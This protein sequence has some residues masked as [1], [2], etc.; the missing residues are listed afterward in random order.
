MSA[1]KSTDI[2]FISEFRNVNVSGG[3]R[4]AIL[5]PIIFTK[6]SLWRL[7]MSINKNNFV[8]LSL[9]YLGSA[10]IS[11]TVH[12]NF[13]TGQDS[14]FSEKQAKKIDSS[15]HDPAMLFFREF[16]ASPAETSVPVSV[17]DV[18]SNTSTESRMIRV[19]VCINISGMY[20]KDIEPIVVQSFSCNKSIEKETV[21]PHSVA[22]QLSTLFQ[23][24]STSD[25]MFV[26]SDETHI[27]A[28]KLIVSMRSEVFKTM[29]SVN[30]SETATNEIV[31]SDFEPVVVSAFVHFLYTDDCDVQ[32]LSA[33]AGELLK[34]A[35]RYEVMG[36]QLMCET[37]LSSSLTTACVVDR[38]FFAE[39]YGA[40]KLKDSA[41]AYIAKHKAELI[42]VDPTF[43]QRLPV[44][45]VHE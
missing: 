1:F 3:W 16:K 7:A 41:M 40:K 2:E 26:T 23:D 34:M 11:V 39:L 37:H 10:T 42:K 29:L 6:D 13:L 14:F 4:P 22:A 38:L 36:L 18:T 32:V 21:G 27:S 33:W 8:S 44:E 31:I 30:M 25:L 45:L 17:S 43:L 9:T 5:G 12:V 19:K 20:A 28:H 15:I 24:L 35:H